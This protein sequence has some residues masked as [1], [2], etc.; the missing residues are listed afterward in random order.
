MPGFQ[1]MNSALPMYIETFSRAWRATGS[2]VSNEA[3]TLPFAVR[4]HMQQCWSF[5]DCFGESTVGCSC[6]EFHWISK[7]SV[8]FSHPQVWQVKHEMRD[9]TC[10]DLVV[11]GDVE[12]NYR[13]L[14][15]RIKQFSGNFDCFPSQMCE[16]T[17]QGSSILNDIES[18]IANLQWLKLSTSVEPAKQKNFEP[19]FCR[20]C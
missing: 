3:V 10:E 20:F 5:W 15:K 7:W 11:Y 12:V 18:H 17:N 14:N 13:P 6:H 19:R 16:Q 8:F 1:P 9:M 4:S 2:C